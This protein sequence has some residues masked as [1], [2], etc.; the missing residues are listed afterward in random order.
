[1]RTT[2]HKSEGVQEDNTDLDGTQY[3]DKPRAH[4]RAWLTQNLGLPTE[5]VSTVGVVLL[6]THTQTSCTP[7]KP[8]ETPRQPCEH[9]AKHSHN[10]LPRALQVPMH[11]SPLPCNTFHD[12]QIN[13][14]TCTYTNSPLAVNATGS[15]VAF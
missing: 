15:H 8:R 4:T 12:N 13:R 9:H 1:R 6:T 10:T 7:H 2:L 3:Q 5:E 11:C 14:I